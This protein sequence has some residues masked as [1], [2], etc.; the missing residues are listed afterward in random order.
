VEPP[1]PEWSGLRL[2]SAQPIS[3][4]QL[5]LMILSEPNGLYKLPFRNVHIGLNAFACTMHHPIAEALNQ[6]P[7]G[8]DGAAAT[9]LDRLKPHR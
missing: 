1:Q 9:T 8:I 4:K 5:V 6:P 2:T 7:A 3:T